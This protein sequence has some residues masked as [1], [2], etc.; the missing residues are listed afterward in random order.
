MLK[1]TLKL[2]GRAIEILESQ[3]D[4]EPLYLVHGNSSAANVFEA[5]LDGALGR[6]K[7]LIAVSLPGHGGSAP[8]DGLGRLSIEEIGRVVAR[9]VRELGHAR[10]WLLG[11]SLGGHAVLEALEEFPGVLGVIL[12]SAP[13]IAGATIGAAF[14]ADPSKGLLFKG[15][16]DDEEVQRLASC[17][18]AP[19]LVDASKLVSDNIRRTDP[20]FRPALGASLALGAIRDELAAVA[21]ARIPIAVFAAAHDRFLRAEYYDALPVQRLWRNEVTWFRESGHAINLYEPARFERILREFT[22]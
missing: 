3:G 21:T 5:L 22:S 9:V 6:Q 10:Y 18:V 16:L 14:H 20:T 13:P 2:D 17:F 15:A 8:L 1:R 19:E 12:V 4:G 7:K 11:A